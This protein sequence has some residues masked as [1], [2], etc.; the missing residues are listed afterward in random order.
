M[1]DICTNITGRKDLY[2]EN[3]ISIK[4]RIEAVKLKLEEA[5]LAKNERT[6]LLLRASSASV[7]AKGSSGTVLGE[8]LSDL[9][10]INIADND[11][12]LLENLS[13]ESVF[14]QNPYH[15]FVV[16]MGDDTQKA[17]ENVSALMSGNPIWKELEAV[18]N[19]RIYVMERTLFNIKPNAK[20]AEAYEK[21]IT[22]LLKDE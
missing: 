17:T 14:R 9:G 13:V 11:T 10:L 20:W 18:K 5:E 2:D 3:G 4:K 7:K 22:I 8:M 16:T 19:N 6:V 12:S 1:L 21:L 15:I